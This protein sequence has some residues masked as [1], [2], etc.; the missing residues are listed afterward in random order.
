MRCFVPIFH[1]WPEIGTNQNTESTE[2]RVY[3]S[4]T[5]NW[6]GLKVAVLGFKVRG[7]A[8][9]FGL[10]QVPLSLSLSIS[11]ALLTSLLFFIC[12]PRLSWTKKLE[13]NKG[14]ENLRLRGDFSF[15]ILRFTLKVLLA[16]WSKGC[17]VLSLVSTLW[18]QRLRI[19]CLEVVI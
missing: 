16:L 2:R 11:S 7:L 1:I 5:Y 8:L 18:F 19:S 10:G 9:G 14:A 4:I 3:H 15:C 13:Y 6:L 17:A 12:L